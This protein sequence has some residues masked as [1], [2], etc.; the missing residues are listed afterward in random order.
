M[1]VMIVTHTTVFFPHDPIAAPLW[2]WLHFAVPIFIFCSAYLFFQ[3]HTDSPPH[4]WHYLQKRFIRLLVPYYLFLM[5]F[6]PIVF[7]IK[8]ETI[9]FKYFLASIFLFAGVDINWLVLL[10]LM[11]TILLPFIIYTWKHARI[12]FWSFFLLSLGSSVDILFFDTPLPYRVIMWIPW[13]LILYGT[14]FYI[15]RE[16]KHKSMRVPLIFFLILFG[17]LYL[18][19]ELR[20]ATT[21]F[22]HN[23]YPPNLFYLSYGV[24]VTIVLTRIMKPIGTFAP[25]FSILHFFSKNSYQIYFVHY[26]VLTGI[27]VSLP[28]NAWHWTTFT[29]AVITFTVFLQYLL[30]IITK[31]VSLL[32]NPYRI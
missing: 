2:N 21:I 27:A 30:I 25:I 1:L 29:L 24:F 20:G 16:K 12:L 15:Q 13:S 17:I 3:K 26:I 18:V 8:P 10:F 9:T 11:I 23:K 22:I 5:V 14:F 28:N 31:K 7:L 6:L 19:Q 32:R 4:F